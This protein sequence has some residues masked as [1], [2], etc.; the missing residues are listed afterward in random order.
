MRT[1]I[2]DQLIQKILQ[3]EVTVGIIGMGYVGL[4][5]VLRFCEEGFRIL[6]FDVDSRK[7]ETLRKGRSYLKSIPSSRISQ[8]VR[9]RHLDV[10]DDFSRLGEPDCILICGPTPLT[11]KMEPDLQYIEKTT[12]A[13]RKH[14][15]KGQLIVLESTS[16]P[17]TTEELILPQLE[18][19]GLK[20]GKDFFLAFSPEREDPGNR[21]FTTH[22]K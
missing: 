18:S 22:Q 14:L 11:E 10:T 15:R 20:A 3:K 5:L 17:G 2:V 7:V 13:I 16:Y 1:K 21:R 12:E 8:F 6:G 19:K 4:P 9:S